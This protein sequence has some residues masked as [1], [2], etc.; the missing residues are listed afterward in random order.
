MRAIAAKVRRGRRR[1]NA[2]VRARDGEASGRDFESTPASKEK[3]D[4]SIT[5]FDYHKTNVF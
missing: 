5:I 2:A 3:P 4:K 1:A